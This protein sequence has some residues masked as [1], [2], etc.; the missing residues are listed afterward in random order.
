MAVKKI[1]MAAAV[2]A[3]CAAV[4]APE[5]RAQGLGGWPEGILLELQEVNLPQMRAVGMRGSEAVLRLMEQYVDNSYRFCFISQNYMIPED[6][7]EYL[8]V[9]RERML[10]ALIGYPEYNH[11]IMAQVLYDV[12]FFIIVLTKGPNDLRRS[13]DIR[14]SRIDYL[15]SDRALRGRV[16][17][18][19]QGMNIRPLGI[20]VRR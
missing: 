14:M 6:Q 3:L 16:L 15:K 19:I 13:D 4:F 11:L 9:G 8:T 10:V 5:A 20:E 1:R 18:S 2:F 7:K 12:Q 17:D